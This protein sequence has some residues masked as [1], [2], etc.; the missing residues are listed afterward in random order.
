MSIIDS[1]LTKDAAKNLALAQARHVVR[2]ASLDRDY[3]EHS[4][5]IFSDI[6]DDIDELLVGTIHEFKQSRREP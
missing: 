2:M 5:K 1:V 6:V 4:R 3:D